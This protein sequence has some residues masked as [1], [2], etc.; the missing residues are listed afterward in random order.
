MNDEAA[1]PTAQESL[2]LRFP[3]LAAADEGTYD[4]Q[5]EAYRDVLTQLTAQL[6][7]LKDDS[8]THAAPQSAW[9]ESPRDQY[10]QHG[11]HNKHGKKHH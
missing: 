10:A 3:H 4:Q 6:D 9:N 8:E 2:D 7:Q 11:N 1:E 5:I